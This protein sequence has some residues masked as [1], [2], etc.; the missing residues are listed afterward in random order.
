MT[1]SIA[2]FPYIQLF[3][4]GDWWDLNPRPLGPQPRALPAELQ[5]PYFRNVRHGVKL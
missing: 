5:P 4:K 2:V 1:V 3:R